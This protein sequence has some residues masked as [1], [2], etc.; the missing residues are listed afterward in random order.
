MSVSSGMLILI[1]NLMNQ[2][3]AFRQSLQLVAQRITDVFGNR[4]NAIHQ[5]SKAAI[6][7]AIT[8]YL[9]LVTMTATIYD[10]CSR[11]CSYAYSYRKL[12]M[13]FLAPC[14][15]S[16]ALSNSNSW[17]WFMPV[18][19]LVKRKLTTLLVLYTP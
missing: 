11:N 18:K 10:A 13:P 5:I 17:T 2:D 15:I 16:L 1:P 14:E 19:L 12:L 7:S 9:A 4:Q 3:T 6:V 8:Y